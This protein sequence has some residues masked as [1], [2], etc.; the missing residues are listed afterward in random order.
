VLC[1]WIL[2]PDMILADKPLLFKGVSVTLADTLAAA[3]APLCNDEVVAYLLTSLLKEFD[4]L[5][6]SVMA[7]SNPMS[8]SEVYTNLLSFE[9]R[10][11]Q[12]HGTPN[13]GQ[14]PMA[15]YTSYGGRGD[16][17]GGRSVRRSGGHNDGRSNDRDP[18]NGDHNDCA[19]CQ[20]CGRAN[21]QVPQCWYRYDDTYQKD[22]MPSTALA[23]APSY[24]VDANCY[25]GTNVT[26]HIT[27][28]L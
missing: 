8:L 22:E 6:T 14:A 5:V 16:R 20:I 19:R 7:R 28:D 15:N 24:S 13:L 1:L 18:N 26:D 21:H 10:L 27:N 2:A 9:M 25:S 3:G 12:R 4:P 23:A 11:V 17:T